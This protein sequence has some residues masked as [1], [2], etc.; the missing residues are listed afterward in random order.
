MT[1]SERGLEG[2]E[3]H[4][5]IVW[6]LTSF[7]E[8]LQGLPEGSHTACNLTL[9]VLCN[10]ELDMAEHKLVIQESGLVIVC[11]CLLEVVHDEVHWSQ[12]E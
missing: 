1:V 6:W 2:L 10:G 3:R 12:N 8:G 11:S 9:L 5:L 4:L 7:R